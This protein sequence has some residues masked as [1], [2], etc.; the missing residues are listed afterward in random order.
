MD[1][2]IIVGVVHLSTLSTRFTIYFLKNLRLVSSVADVGIFCN[3]STF[4]PRRFQKVPDKAD[5]GQLIAKNQ[6]QRNA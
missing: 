3:L 2:L 4:I 6:H 1:K 5:G